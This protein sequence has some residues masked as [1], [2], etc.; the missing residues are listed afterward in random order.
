VP[1]AEGAIILWMFSG[2]GK[3][4]GEKWNGNAYHTP[5]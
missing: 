1:P 2:H 5:V 3:D 4:I